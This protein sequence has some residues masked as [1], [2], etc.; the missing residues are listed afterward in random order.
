MATDDVLNELDELVNKAKQGQAEARKFV[1]R[2]GEN[3]AFDPVKT[4]A[5]ITE[6]QIAMWKRPDEYSDV[7]N[8][9]EALNLFK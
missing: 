6:E 4:S 3:D 9:E 7:K 2:G 1:Q 5:K 8:I